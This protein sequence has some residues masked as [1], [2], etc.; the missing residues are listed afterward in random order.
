MENRNERMNK[1]LNYLIDIQ[2]EHRYDKLNL[3]Y[4]CILLS[5]ELK[6]LIY[7]ETKIHPLMPDSIKRNLLQV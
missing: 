7:I 1:Y 3:N 2:Y 5:H 4:Y 6:Q